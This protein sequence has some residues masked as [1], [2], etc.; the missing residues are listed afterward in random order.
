MAQAPVD[1]PVAPSPR[2]EQPRA[3]KPT[4]PPPQRTP[5]T[6]TARSDA[7]LPTLPMGL[8]RMRATATAV[9]A[10]CLVTMAFELTTPRIELV[11]LA[12]SALLVLLLVTLG[13]RVRAIGILALVAGGIAAVPVLGARVGLPLAETGWLF[14]VLPAVG[15]L[16]WFV[17][18]M[19]GVP[20]VR[21]LGVGLLLGVVGAVAA[22]VWP[23]LLVHAARR[24]AEHETLSSMAI[25]AAVA[26][27]TWIGSRSARQLA[28]SKGVAFVALR[29][30]F[31]RITTLLASIVAALWAGQAVETW[32][33]RRAVGTALESV[34]S[35]AGW[36]I[37]VPVFVALVWAI[38][39]VPGS[40]ALAQL[41]GRFSQ[42]PIG[43]SLL[44]ISLCCVAA[45]M[46]ARLNPALV[47]GRLAWIALAA[48]AAYAWMRLRFA[49]PAPAPN[50]PL[51]LVLVGD[52]ARG[53]AEMA[54]DA[55]GIWRAGQ[56]TLLAAPAMADRT[57]GEHVYAAGLAGKIDALFPTRAVYLEDWAEAQPEQWPALPIRELYAP[58]ELWPQIL[59]Q[60]VEPSAVVFAVHTR[61]TPLI[62]FIGG[63]GLIFP[64]I[65]GAISTGFLTPRSNAV[66]LRPGLSRN[67]LGDL[68]SETCD[69][70]KALLAR[71]K[72]LAPEPAPT[73]V[74][75]IMLLC[76]PSQLDL[77]D[78]VARAIHGRQDGAGRSIESWVGALEPDASGFL[79]MSRLPLGLWRHA[80]VLVG[81]LVQAT[82]NSQSVVRRLVQ[83]LVGML[84]RS[85]TG[86]F[87][88]V[89]VEDENSSGPIG[90]QRSLLT[91][92]I[93][94]GVIARVISVR[95]GLAAAAGWTALPAS[96]YAG[97]I[98]LTTGEAPDVAADRVAR[99]LLDLE[100][101]PLAV[102]SVA[103]DANNA[104]AQ[105]VPESAAAEPVADGWPAAGSF[106][107]VETREV[108]KALF[109]RSL[110]T[111][112]EAVIRTYV[113]GHP[114]QRD[115]LQE[116]SSMATAAERL[117]TTGPPDGVTPD[118]QEFQLPNELAPLLASIESR[119]R[120]ARFLKSLDNAIA[121][122]PMLES[123]DE[124]E[125]HRR[126]RESR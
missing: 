19:W 39:R 54:A 100:L 47:P 18:L 24:F 6:G 21:T 98:R 120:Y 2:V 111:P 44:F 68:A 64:V 59:G 7:L 30:A 81:R 63:H 25:V 95:S 61:R 73:V 92:G 27:I 8:G 5:P 106:Y 94:R 87:E 53:L 46:N 71:L 36:A 66:R 70:K 99:K 96:T 83:V 12:G 38:Y 48:G 31:F 90:L 33:G 42:G 110:R 75:H 86:E 26:P 17:L 35:A 41:R 37:L 107:G 103:P 57:A 97:E 114:G 101:T 113:R 3:A 112:V 49:A 67:D 123:L 117:A 121:V 116:L 28:L 34:E 50:A 125:K 115:I 9:I 91:A 32:V 84:G 62:D 13:L 79:R 118:P 14:G 16:A 11:W 126:R 56:V 15:T 51:W 119:Q 4:E 89:V 55:A 22:T 20:G 122:E 72:Q 1:V 88:V 82:D 58:P 69:S 109:L 124:A 85:W 60:Y 80:A 78:R 40:L 76:P 104:D 43:E 52:D 105:V 10:A 45:G 23:V 29:N 102:P 65:G 108:V 74:R 93:T 77:A